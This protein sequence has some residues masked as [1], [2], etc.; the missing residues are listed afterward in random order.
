MSDPFAAHRDT[1]LGAL[2]ADQ[3]KAVATVEAAW[4]ASHPHLDLPMAAQE[5]IERD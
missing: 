4:P 5:D 1:V 3:P 2:V